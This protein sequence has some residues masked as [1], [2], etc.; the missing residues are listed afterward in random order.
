MAR[1]KTLPAKAKEKRPARLALM[2]LHA[3]G[4]S[5]L[6]IGMVYVAL[7]GGGIVHPVGLVMLVALVILLSMLTPEY[8]KM[9]HGQQQSRLGK[10]A[11]WA[12]TLMTYTSLLFLAAGLMQ[13]VQH[14]YCYGFFGAQ[15]SCLSVRALELFITILN[16]IVYLLI[17]GTLIALLWRGRVGSRTM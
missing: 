2:A 6:V 3:L 17:V 1:P 11:M 10:A 4:F 13:D 8:E 16:P 14:T 12:A 5:L 15:T 7:A 9:M